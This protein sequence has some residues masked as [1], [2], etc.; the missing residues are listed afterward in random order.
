[1]KKT[2]LKIVLSMIMVIAFISTLL[3]FSKVNA[4]ETLVT[5]NNTEE[6]NALDVTDDLGVDQ[7]GDT[8]NTYTEQQTDNTEIYE[9]D[10]YKFAQEDYIMDQTVNGN[11]FIMC[12]GDVKITG[13]V[14]GSLYVLAKNIE[15]S[16]EA[17]IV[18]A[19][20]A[21]GTNVKLDA[22]VFDFYVA[23]QNFE[24]GENTLIQRDLRA[25]AQN[26]DLLGT[27]YRNAFISSGAINTSRDDMSL[28]I[29]GDL[30]YSSKE[31]IQNEELIAPSGTIKFKQV[32]EKE[33]TTEKD[34]ISNKFMNLI[35]KVIFAI[36]IYIILTV[37]APKFNEKISNYISKKSI[38]TCFIGL[39]GIIAI[40]LISILL[41]V[42]VIGLPLGFI[43]LGL[44]VIIFALSTT[45]AKIAIS[46]KLAEKIKLD[47]NIWTKMISVALVVI[48]IYV[49]KL[50]PIV[51]GLISIII[52]LLGFGII[53]SNTFEKNK[54]TQ[55]SE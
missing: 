5:T 45:I 51:S 26:S 37:A 27:I 7:E 47:K 29:Y 54:D 55:I 44:Y 17:Y 52:G 3:V 19:I 10:L 32:E 23:A 20:Y 25:V 13:K 42:T 43:L 49:L 35:Q 53:I 4:T 11:A 16:S 31:K 41:M 39:L 36:A 2:S 21:C 24:M 34:N 30:E 9:D 48:V 6:T 12:S 50:I 22:P 1:M 38:K 40:P 33:Q 18:D 14:N 8:S 28:L 46:N 15:I